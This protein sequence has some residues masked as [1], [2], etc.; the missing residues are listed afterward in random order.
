MVAGVGVMDTAMSAAMTEAMFA[1][2]LV[3]MHMPVV[4]FAARLVSVAAVST[5]EAEMASTEVA[6]TVADAG[7]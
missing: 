7:N 6:D 5:V 3:G 2:T 1:G 4:V